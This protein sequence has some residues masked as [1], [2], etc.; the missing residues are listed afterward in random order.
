MAGQRWPTSGPNGGGHDTW[1]ETPFKNSWGQVVT[2]N[3][4]TTC[5]PAMTAPHAVPLQPTARQLVGSRFAMCACHSQACL[6]S[7]VN[8]PNVSPPPWSAT[9]ADW[10]PLPHVAATSA[11]ADEAKG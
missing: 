11:A 1:S 2:C 5:S 10:V 4:T 9:S 6:T 3:A 8:S 7:P